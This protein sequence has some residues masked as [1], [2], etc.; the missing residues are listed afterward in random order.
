METLLALKHWIR[1]ALGP[2]PPLFFP[3]A[4][5]KEGQRARVDNDTELVIEG[6]PRS[7][8]SFAVS[9]F[10]L[11][12][13]RPVRLAHHLHA[14]A[15]IIWAARRG[16]PA[17]VLIREPMP[18]VSSLVIRH[19]YISVKMALC[20]YIRFYKTIAPCRAQIVVGLFDEVTNDFGAV[21]RRI[22]QRFGTSFSVFEHNAAGV[23]K[24]FEMIELQNRQKN[25][26]AVAELRIARPSHV[27][28]K[29]KAER[30]LDFEAKKHRHLVAAAKT[31][32]R[33]FAGQAELERAG[34][35]QEKF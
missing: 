8:N 5:F 24:S 12:Q 16:L 27:R 11:A 6:F 35:R 3:L 9:A 7:G 25:N 29:L 34:L 23:Q 20:E 4:Q 14:P 17:L 30:H 13:A 26:G 19:P 22:N 18:A 21:I 10:R 15:Q 2:Y 33:D 1:I 31:V 28:E 32:F